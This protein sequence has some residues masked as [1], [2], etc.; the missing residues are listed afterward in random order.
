MTQNAPGQAHRE[1]I[2]L[3]ELF[4][5]FPDDKTAEN[6]FIANRWPDGI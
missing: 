5:M 1:G 4:E 6:W 3:L 2:T